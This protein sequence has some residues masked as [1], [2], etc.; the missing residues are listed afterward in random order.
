[1]A[2]LVPLPFVMRRPPK[3]KKQA[4]EALGH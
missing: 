3:R 1:A 4:A 2:M